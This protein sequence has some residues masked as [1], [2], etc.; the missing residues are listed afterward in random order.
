MFGAGVLKLI[1]LRVLWMVIVNCESLSVNNLRFRVRVRVMVEV[2]VR[3]SGNTLKYVRSNVHS[4]KCP[5]GQTSIRSNVHSGKC[6]GSIVDITIKIIFP[7]FFS[8]MAGFY[9]VTFV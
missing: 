9:G 2:W 7:W 6:T 1:L 4:V 8:F 3:V 5:F